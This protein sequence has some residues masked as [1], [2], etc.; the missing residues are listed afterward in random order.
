VSAKNACTAD[1]NEV[2]DKAELTWFVLE[3]EV[4]S[5]APIS[6]PSTST[7]FSLSYTVPD[8]QALRGRPIKSK[9]L[10]PITRHRLI[11]SILLKYTR[12]RVFS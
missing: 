2:S 4:E 1:P 7:F 8:A 9:E 6:V 10:I 5:F 12:V 3:V 11:L